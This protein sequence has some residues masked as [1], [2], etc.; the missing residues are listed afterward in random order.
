MSEAVPLPSFERPPVNEVVLAVS[1]DRPQRMGIAHLAA[2]WAE[3]L[4]GEL[5]DVE[6]QP[7]FHRPIELL[8]T[9]NLQP[10]SMQLLDRPPAPRLWAKSQDGTALAQLQTD[11]FAYNWR[12]LNATQA[13]YP[14]WPVVE[15]AFLRYFRLM[16]GF[17]EAEGFGP[18]TA[19]QCEV[20]YIN[21][22]KPNG[23][24]QSHGDLDKVLSVIGSAH[25]FLPRPETTQTSVAF[26]ITTEGV[27]RGR[28]HVNVQPAFQREDNS[29]SVIVTITARGEPIGEGEDGIM[30]F[31]RLGHEW[32]VR[33]FAGVTTSDMH[34]EW[35]RTA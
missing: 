16:T 23:V 24:W 34:D 26:L 18:L 25:E 33:G 5:P 1:F 4:R 15:G 2:F 14:R 28:L 8:D 32:V 31:L 9:P 27:R 7:P 19:R 6:E 10:I 12:D 20:T 13:A 17:I 3:Q 22:I 30:A 21:Q 29:P 11:W 35:G